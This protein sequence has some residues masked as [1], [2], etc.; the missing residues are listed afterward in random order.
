M[1]KGEWNAIL[2]SLAGVAI[3]FLVAVRVSEAAPHV[4]DE[5]AYF[6][7]ARALARGQLIVPT[8]PEP[9]SM[10]VPFVVDANRHRSAKY[11]PGWSYKNSPFSC[12]RRR[13]QYQARI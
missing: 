5:M 3:A 7:Q 9:R 2:P 6:R 10:L 8:P 12:S 1:R 13:E 4:E 11:S